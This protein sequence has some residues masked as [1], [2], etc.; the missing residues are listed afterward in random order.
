[1]TA[2]RW[3]QGDTPFDVDALIARARRLN[4]AEVQDTPENRIE[5]EAVLGTIAEYLAGLDD[6]RRTPVAKALVSAVESKG[7][8]STVQRK[9]AR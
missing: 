2:S 4:V 8:V 9:G 3:P 6:R 5:A 1:M 7:F